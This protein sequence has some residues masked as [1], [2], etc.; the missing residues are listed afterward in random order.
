MYARLFCL[1]PHSPLSAA[2]VSPA[3]GA[4]AQPPSEAGWLCVVEGLCMYLSAEEGARSVDEL[5]A[6]DDDLLT[7]EDLLGDDRSQPSEEVALAV[8]DLKHTTH[9]LSAFPYLQHSVEL[10][11]A[12]R[13]WLSWP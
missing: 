11:S 10:V 2:L 13:A 4:S 7:V 9:P 1:Q 3:F 5:A 8:N 6:D 12:V